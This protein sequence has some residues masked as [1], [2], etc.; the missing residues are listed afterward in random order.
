METKATIAALSEF[1]PRCFYLFEQ[2]RRPLKVGIWN[3]IKA[4]LGD[5]ITNLELTYALR[6]YTNNRCYLQSC[7]TAGTPRI[8]LNGE[9]AGH[10]TESEA[11][12]AAERLKLRTAK[13]KARQQE[14]AA[15]PAPA[16]RRLSLGDLK[17]AA[18]ARAANTRGGA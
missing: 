14:K 6:S 11:A 18:A 3:D 13:W 10:V 9:V 7:L 8:D 15:P 16:A 1:F 2:R 12:H 17:Q 5:A 4:E